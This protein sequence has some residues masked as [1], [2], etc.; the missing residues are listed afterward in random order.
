MLR[1]ALPTVNNDKIGAV[2]LEHIIML[3]DN[4]SSLLVQ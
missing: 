3:G 2:V 1:A 4:K